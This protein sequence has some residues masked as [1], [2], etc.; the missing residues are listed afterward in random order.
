MVVSVD[1]ADEVALRWSRPPSPDE[2]LGYHVERAVVE[3][4]SEDEIVRLK[5]DTPP[6]A[7]PSV[8]A[9]KAIGAVRHASRTEPGQGPTSST[10]ATST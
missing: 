8:G 7:E 2:S 3:V 4:F 5:K 1:V 9:I 6:L 10:T